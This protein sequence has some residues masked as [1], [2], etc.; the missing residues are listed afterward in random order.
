MF[1]SHRWL[2]DSSLYVLFTQVTSWLITVCSVHTGDFMTH[3]CMFCSHRWLH[4]SSLH[5]LFTQV[6]SWLITVCSVHTGDFMTHHCVFCSHRWLHDSSLC[7]LFTQVTSWLITVCSVHTG[8]FMTH[9]FWDP[10][11]Q[12]LSLLTYREICPGC[13]SFFSDFQRT[14]NCWQCLKFAQILPKS[15]LLLCSVLLMWK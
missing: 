4:D 7:V 12:I 11:T 6:T 9:H 13:S 5:V 3:H 14:L 8:D 15:F 10:L 1:C 2:H